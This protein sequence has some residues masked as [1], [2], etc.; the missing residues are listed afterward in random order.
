[1]L[2][3]NIKMCDFHITLRARKKSILKPRA[4]LISSSNLC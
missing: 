2:F 4:A 1:M 3:D